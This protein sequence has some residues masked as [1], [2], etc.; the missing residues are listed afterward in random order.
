MP[1]PSGGSV[2][3]FQ[4]EVEP[5]EGGEKI[6]ITLVHRIP[7]GS[8]LHY[9]P[10]LDQK[11]KGQV[12]LLVVPRGGAELQV[13]TGQPDSRHAVWTIPSQP[14]LIGL[15]YGARGFDEAK[16]KSF[17]AKDPELISQLA[18]YA[19]KTTLVE[20]LLANAGNGQGPDAFSAAL[21][22]V[23]GRQAGAAWNKNAPAD[24]QTAALLMSLNPSLGSYDPLATNADARIRQSA[25]L[26]A[27]IGSIFFGS[28]F[29]LGAS[30][31]NLVLNLR[32]MAFPDTEFRSA[33]TQ[34]DKLK[35][36]T[37]C[38]KKDQLKQRTK[39][40]YLWMNRLDDEQAPAIHLA[41][42]SHYLLLKEVTLPLTREALSPNSVR[43]VR[44]WWLTANGGPKIPVIALPA[45][46]GKD[47]CLKIP[48]KIVP[49]AYNLTGAF[50]WQTLKVPEEVVFHEIPSLKGA[51]L[52]ATSL[53]R[54]VSA[55]GATQVEMEGS[56]FRFVEKVRLKNGVDPLAPPIDLSF[57]HQ[58]L[59]K[60]K[61]ALDTQ[62][63]AVG[64]HSL[65]LLQPGGA[66]AQVA[67]AVADPGPK[68]SIGTPR[69]SP[70]T[71]ASLELRE[72]E[73]SMRRPFSAVLTVTGV[74][75]GPA[76]GLHCDPSPEKLL[77]AGDATAA[78]LRLNLLSATEW[79]V[80]AEPKLLGNAGCK[81]E[82]TA[83]DETAGRSP[84]VELGSLVSLPDVEKFEL[85]E[86]RVGT[87]HYAGTLWG[88]ELERIEKTGWDERQPVPVTQL[89]TP[90]ANGKQSV[91]VSLPWP[92][93]SPHAPL[94]VWLR[95]EEKPRRTNVR[96]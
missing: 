68:P 62:L 66:V 91:K 27:S 16:V 84:A 1:C 17:I 12:S 48:P 5:P 11:S 2:T 8:K 33:F 4:L 75:V 76:L 30:G 92:A 26:A 45:A 70:N 43:G 25:S 31:A 64:K 49:G 73:I 34:M 69:F 83:I 67:F 18:G 51:R 56:D 23:A 47:M 13:L 36:Y 93:P 78:S 55:K 6:P 29:G 46:D 85:T 63:L 72:G 20:R 28:T 3:E 90:E 19:E 86:E 65:E 44:Q 71:S 77:K 94:F 88:T 42:P 39:L 38:G 81:L 41:Q 53:A 87:G 21:A 58:P 59:G 22:G 24:Q 35:G 80:T 15:V 7:A 95:G 79:F 89:P 82:A 61:V 40:T 96:L 60:L 10:G 9:H 57:Q 52:S 54:L 32:S 74:T 14:E 37:L 50:D